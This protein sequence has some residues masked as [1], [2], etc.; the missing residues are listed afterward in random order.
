MLTQELKTKVLK[1]QKNEL[2]EHI[3]YKNLASVIKD[4][5]QS[6]ILIRISNEEL[7]HYEFFKSITQEEVAPDSFKIFLY[8]FIS[9]IFGLNFGLKLME[10]GEDLAQDAYDRL[11]EISPQIDDII[12]DE[13]KHE[14]ELIDLINEERLKY[15]SSIVLGLNDALV[16]LTGAL[17]GFTLAL[18]NTKLIAIIGLITGIAASMSMA[19]SEYLSTKHEETDKTPLKACIYTG[20]TYV[21]TVMFLIFPYLLF[22]NIFVCLGITVTNALLLILIFTFYTSVA[23]GLSFKKRFFE[24]ASISLG[25]AVINF[26]IGFA[27]R[28]VFGVEV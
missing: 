26:F 15:V 10:N 1:A 6:E 7:T 19:A 25:I 5:Q 22:K 20:I 12:K 3:I 17:A 9:R 24:M 28:K 11:K 4:K 18:Q 13:E 8:V 2:T 14:T 21:G 27:I 23:K 16:E